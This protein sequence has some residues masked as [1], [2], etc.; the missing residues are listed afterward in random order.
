[1]DWPRLVARFGEHWP[2]L[3][4]HLVSFH[5]V[6]PDH[7]DAVPAGLMADMAARLAAQPKDA[8]NRVCY[9]TLLSR[10]QYLH[11]VRV[12]GYVDARLQPHGTMTPDE[13]AK[14]TDAIGK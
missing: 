1:M 6:Y 13:V 14:W 2:V 9:G 4:G 7:R 3:L 11:D 12:L 10:E 8:H 5:F